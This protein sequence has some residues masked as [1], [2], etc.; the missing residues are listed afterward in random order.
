MQTSKTTKDI[1]RCSLIVL[2]VTLLVATLGVKPVAAH[3]PEAAPP[4]EVE[5][6]PIEVLDGESLVEISIDDVAAYHGQQMGMG[7]SKCLCLAWAFRAAQAGIEALWGEETPQRDDIK[8]V[9]TH[10]CRG[11]RHCFEFVTGTGPDTGAATRGTFSILLPDGTEVKSLDP[12][13]R[14]ELS[15][16]TSAGTFTVTIMR[17]S[18]GESFTA[19]VKEEIFPKDFFYLRKKVKFGIPE[20][21]TEEE[22]NR[23]VALY[24]ETR[25]KFLTL[26][27]WQLFEGIEEPEEPFPAAAV[28]FTGTLIA[29]MTVGA[30]Y[31]WRAGRR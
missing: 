17:E 27:A 2:C 6:T 16:Q 7:P 21:A 31:S 5:M 28:G 8:I 3:V 25:D 10:P 14:K 24:A 19:V 29:L 18:T 4:P 23:Y 15:K 1:S 9:S 20:P 12:N 11:S 13:T 26:P 22:R 30:V